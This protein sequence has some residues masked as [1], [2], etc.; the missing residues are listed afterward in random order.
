MYTLS[1]SIKQRTSS[2]LQGNNC[3]RE[4]KDQLPHS[5]QPEP[6]PA[7][8]T[9]A[10]PKTSLVFP[11]IEPQPLLKAA[12]VIL[13]LDGSQKIARAGNNAI[14]SMPAKMKRLSSYR[15]DKTDSERRITYDPV[16]RPEVSNLFDAGGLIDGSQSRKVGLGG[17]SGVQDGGGGKLEAK[18]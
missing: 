2:P 5:N 1:G 14:M 9:T 16:N 3:S 13:G 6:L 7:A 4:G 12:P 10:L 15:R 17:R 18:W 8:L 11:S